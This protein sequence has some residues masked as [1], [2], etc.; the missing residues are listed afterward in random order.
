MEEK[1]LI[2]GFQKSEITEHHI[3]QNLSRFADQKN[4]QVLEKLSR[5]EAR[6]YA[7]WK[8][9]TKTDVKPSKIKII[10]YTL[11][12]R[13][14]G[15]TFSVKLM[16]AGEK[17]AEIN[18]KKVLKKFP[19]AKAILKDE[20]DHEE[21]LVNMIDEEAVKH[22]GSMVL[23]INDALVEITGTLAGLTFAL[24]NTA[25]VGLAGTVTGISATLSMAASEY[26]SKRTEGNSNAFRAATYTGIAYLVAVFA[27]V[28]PYFLLKSPLGALSFTLVNVILIIFGFTFFSSVIRSASFKR[29]FLEMISISLGV[30]FVSFVIGMFARNVLNIQA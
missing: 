25:L 11:L 4:R 5:D 2:L 17:E 20:E 9:Y 7:F 10:F 12:A 14:L 6:H 15:L 13:I 23:G 29:S 27:L 24:N 18:Y 16:E 22:I 28:V 3:Y 26:L 8:K 1:R 21:A 19:G 30:A